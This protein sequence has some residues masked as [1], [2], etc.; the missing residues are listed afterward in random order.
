MART[1]AVEISGTAGGEGG[2]E[3]I[4]NASSLVRDRERSL[5]AVPPPFDSTSRDRD[6]DCPDSEG[7]G[8]A[9]DADR[10]RFAPGTV[11]P[12]AESDVGD[13]LGLLPRPD[14]ES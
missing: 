6:R 7:S 9:A 4:D 14:S 10:D 13:V 8:T 3:A 2:F 11:D 5:G 12:G 1:P